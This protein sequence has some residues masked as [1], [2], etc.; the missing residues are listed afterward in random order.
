MFRVCF[1]LDDFSD[2]LA[3]DFDTIDDARQAILKLQDSP[4]YYGYAPELAQASFW[5]VDE[6][7]KLV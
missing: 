6:N 4:E 5:V 7:G 1:K 2:T 3:W